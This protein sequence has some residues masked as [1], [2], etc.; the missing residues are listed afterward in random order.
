MKK[1]FLLLLLTFTIS[2][3]GLSKNAGIVPVPTATIAPMAKATMVIDFG[4]G[5]ISTYSGISARSA[6]E[7]LEKVAVENDITMD[8]KKYDF[9]MLVNSINGSENT[10][11]LAWIY[12][13]N[14]KS[15]E[16]GADAYKLKDGDVV[17]WKYI[18]P[19]F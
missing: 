4:G 5:K 15:P 9:G 1:L 17:E 16:V 3:C 14:G 12:Y 7:A 13:V 8:V 19:T 2:G 11:D 10:K 6:F 18:K